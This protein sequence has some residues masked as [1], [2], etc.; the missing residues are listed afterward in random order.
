[1]NN[2]NVVIADDNNELVVM[3]STYLEKNNFNIKNTFS[4]GD[5]LLEYLKSNKIDLLILDICMPEYD[6]FNVLEEI[7]KNSNIYI[8]PSKIILL[9]AFSNES[10]ISRSSKLGADYFLV[11]PIKLNNLLAT[12]NNLFQIESIDTK[13]TNIL[14]SINIPTHVSGYEYLSYAIKLCLNNNN[15]LDNITKELYPEIA[16]NFNSTKERVERSIRNAIEIAYSESGITLNNIKYDKKPKNSQIIKDI[17]TLIN[18]P[19]N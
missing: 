10:V 14:N 9:S 6:G 5:L 17:I 16:K 12:I 4:K 8:K 11:K 3:I 18:N 7:N 13:I 2:L 1:M 19:S 15:L